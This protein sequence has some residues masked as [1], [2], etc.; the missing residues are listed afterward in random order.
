M[1]NEMLSIISMN[2]ITHSGEAK[3]LGIEALRKSRENDNLEAKEMIE[4][5]KEK[6]KEAQEWHFKALIAS[7]ENKLEMD[8]LFIHAEDQMM[9]SDTILVLA[10]ELI[11][12]RI[13]DNKK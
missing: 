13:A 12:I 10:E 3:S 2:I 1:N 7:S 8:M 6:M 11:E 5:A 9:T 4:T